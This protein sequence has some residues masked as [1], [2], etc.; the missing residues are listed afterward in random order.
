MHD[1]TATA[2]RLLGRAACAA[3]AAAALLVG[4][5]ASPPSSPAPPTSAIAPP[6]TDASPAGR[7]DVPDM[8]AALAELVAEAD[9][10]FLQ[11]LNEER[12]AWME[13]MIPPDEPIEHMFREFDLA[14][15][16]LRAGRPD[17]GIRRFSAL[18]NELIAGQVSMASKGPVR[19]ATQRIAAAWL[20]RVAEDALPAGSAGDPWVAPAVDGAAGSAA[21]TRNA[22]L[23]LERLVRADVNDLAA[24]W[25]LFV[26]TAYLGQPADDVPERARIDPA[27]LA[28]EGTLSRFADV[29]TDAGLAG[30]RRQGGAVLDDLDGDGS[31]D[32]MVSSSGLADPLALYLGRGEGTFR[33]ATSGSGLAG[34]TGGIDLVQADYDGDGDRDVLVLRGGGLG[35]A[36]AFPPSLLRNEGG[37]TF[38]DVT[39][40]AGLFRLATGK[41]AAWGDLE[42]DGDLDLYIGNQ[43]V[44]GGTAF[45]NALYANN[46]DGTFDEVAEALGAQALGRTSSVALG[47]MDDDGDLDIV[48]T[49]IDAPSLLLR[50]AG[51]GAD[52]AL[53]PFEDA[54]RDA[55]LGEPRWAS[56][57]VVFDYDNDGHLDLF[58]GDGGRALEA[59]DVLLQDVVADLLGQ[60]AGAERPRLFHNRGDGT[61][62]DATRDAGLWRVLLANGVNAGDL[63]GDGWEDLV[64][65]TGD[66]DLRALVP[67]RAFRNAGDGTFQDVTL[68]GGFGHLQKGASVAFG[69]VDGDG[70]ED[71]HVGM[72][73]VYV[74]DRFPSLLLKNPGHGNRWLTLRLEGTSANRDAIGARVRIDVVGP[75]GARSLHRVMSSGGSWGANSLQLEVG[76][77]AAEAIE[78]VVVVWPSA[79]GEQA[80]QGLAV[81]SAYVLREGDPAPRALSPGAP[82]AP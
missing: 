31:L 64:I 47:D 82:S 72:G 52:G 27:V 33:D 25:L 50:N 17:D 19:E 28:S 67:N 60:S 5:Q 23:E 7:S 54:T 32:L 10:V 21:A 79:T 65:A 22:R 20:R 63:D 80:F 38:V 77:G 61:F 53:L 37:G 29:A 36:G 43:T 81:D 39:H 14:E 57:S 30:A 46:G 49:R 34:L 9:P 2:R 68:A 75:A 3:I 69:D 62:E 12:V 78:R 45:P 55:G 15:E 51:V 76:L 24:R 48:V 44:P 58:V 11:S 66:P 74:G 56:G 70:D 16:L 59:F 1:P 26:T 4:C 40:A 73:G 13:G 8:V 6:S 42:R 41:A 71:V 35:D 18:R